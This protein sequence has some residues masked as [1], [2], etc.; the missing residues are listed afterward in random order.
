MLLSCGFLKRSH[1]QLLRKVYVLSTFVALFVCVSSPPDSC[2]VLTEM[3]S[4]E[5]TLYCEACEKI[6][7]R[8]VGLESFHLRICIPRNFS[9]PVLLRRF[10]EGSIDPCWGGRRFQGGVLKLP[11]TLGMRCGKVSHQEPNHYY[12]N[13]TNKTSVSGSDGTSDIGSWCQI[14]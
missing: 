8:N 2:V 9:K 3:A 14:R 7:L 5:V 6:T 1:Q 10:L 12:H 13:S 11:L 4:K